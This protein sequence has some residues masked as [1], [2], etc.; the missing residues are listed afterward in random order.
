M[1]ASSPAAPWIN[2]P[3]RCQMA[4]IDLAYSGV[5]PPHILTARM[6]GGSSGGGFAR[7]DRAGATS[8]ARA[9]EHRVRAAGANPEDQRP[10]SCLRIDE[11]QAS[12]FA[13][14]SEEAISSS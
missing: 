1:D 10:P 8:A 12:S 14:A 4:S 13:G 6:T 3:P 9:S 7:A 11:L 2:D 5:H